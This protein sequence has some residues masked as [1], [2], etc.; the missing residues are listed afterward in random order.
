MTVTLIILVLTVLMF[1]IGRL[2]SDIVALCALSAL[3][4]FGILTPVEAFSGFSSTVVIMMVG[5]FRCWR[6]HNAD[7]FGKSSGRADNEVGRWKRYRAFPTC[8]NCN[9]SHRSVCKQHGNCGIDDA[10]SCRNGFE[11]GHASCAPSHAAGICKQHGRNAYSYR[12]S[13]EPCDSG[14]TYGCGTQTSG[15][16][17]LSPRRCC[18]YGSG[19]CGDA[20]AVSYALEQKQ[21]RTALTAKG[22]AKPLMHL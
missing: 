14:H 6:S 11:N 5:L 21:K 19:N 16:F 9:I 2:R 15:I 4:L 10:D 18:V 3:L 13:P 20:A 1:A 22:K 7:R 17:L 12:N 8:G